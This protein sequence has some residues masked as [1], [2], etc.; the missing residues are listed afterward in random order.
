MGV[1]IHTAKMKRKEKEKRE[2]TDT[3]SCFILLHR[4]AISYRPILSPSGQW[5]ISNEREIPPVCG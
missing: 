1:I 3:I 4:L 2:Y 5:H